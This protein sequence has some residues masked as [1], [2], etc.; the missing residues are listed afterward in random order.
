LA[1][2]PEKRRAVFIP[3]GL[4]GL[5]DLG[6]R[7]GGQRRAEVAFTRRWREGHDELPLFSG[8]WHI[9]SPA[10]TLAPEEMPQRIPSSFARRRAI[11][12]ES[13]FVTVSVSSIIDV[14]RFWE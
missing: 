2:L 10:Q 8:R 12:N 7:L 5:R 4:W 1:A 3:K 6:A 13:S 9:E 14:L 11:V